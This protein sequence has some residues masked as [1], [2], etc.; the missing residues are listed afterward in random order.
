MSKSLRWVLQPA[1]APLIKR[2]KRSASRG[3]RSLSLRIATLSRLLQPQAPT[4]A[5][6]SMDLEFHA[7]AG[8]PEG[9]LFV[10]G[11]RVGSIAGV[12]RL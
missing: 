8:A 7:E 2:A 3:L 10:N 4:P 12:T 1:P 9:A 11:L 6:D 5:P